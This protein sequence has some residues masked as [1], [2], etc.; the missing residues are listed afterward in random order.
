MIVGDSSEVINLPGAL[1]DDNVTLPSAVGRHASSPQ[2]ELGGKRLAKPA[3][4]RG[5][6][7]REL[8]E[9]EYTY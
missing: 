9:K 3:P 8:R 7:E 6:R 5:V 2:T 4:K 1:H